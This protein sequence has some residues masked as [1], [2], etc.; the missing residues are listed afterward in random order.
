MDRNTRLTRLRQLP[1][2]F[3]HAAAPPPWAPQP[4]HLTD[5]NEPVLAG[6][7]E[8]IP[9]ARASNTLP[10]AALVLGAPGSGKTHL[11]GALHHRPASGPHS[12]T[13]VDVTPPIDP[14]RPL[15]HLAALMVAALA[16]R[17]G[18]EPP[19][20]ARMLA[21]AVASWLAD[22]EGKSA[23]RAVK[24]RELS[25]TR[26]WPEVAGQVSEWMQDRHPELWP[27]LL[28]VLIQYPVP[29]KQPRAVQWLRGDSLSDEEVAELGL[30]AEPGKTSA[31]LENA[32][33]W[34]IASLT[35]LL[36]LDRPL[37]LAFDALESEAWRE[38]RSVLNRMLELV[39]SSGHH[40]LVLACARTDGWT[41]VADGLEASLRDR[42]VRRFELGGCS[43]PQVDRLVAR[44]LAALPGT[45]DGADLFPLDDALSRHQLMDLAAAGRPLAREVLRKARQM[46][47][48]EVSGEGTAESPVEVI[49]VWLDER[50]GLI[51]RELD[52]YPPEDGVLLD[53]IGWALEHHGREEAVACEAL[54]K[55]TGRGQEG[56][57][58]ARLRTRA[59]TFRY[60]FVAG[61]R[62]EP[63]TLA[64]PVWQALRQVTQGELDIPVVV[65]DFRCPVPDFSRFPG[66]S[67]LEALLDAGGYL[68]ELDRRQMARCWAI[69]E[70]RVAVAAQELELLASD[71]E[72]QPVTRAHL[73]VFMQERPQWSPVLSAL[74][75]C[76]ARVRDRRA[77]Q[78]PG[79]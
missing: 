8:L 31:D 49:G 15:R 45:T 69:R 18:T 14:A 37:V 48:R 30:A 35:R 77:K 26:Q 2:P 52:R 4:G 76:A 72:L 50:M 47:M 51:E 42:F 71:G 61:T 27:P 41:R 40:L 9:A 20:L 25:L 65:R 64:D 6:L 34:R 53:G 74:A 22:D 58:T 70:L 12:C 21:R 63:V 5:L 78:N 43:R 32:A 55:P 57:M 73:D 54:V 59:G 17:V 23:R 44:R 62:R 68:L 11:L 66:R 28:E 39:L 7:D 3:R 60:R 79:A 38:R 19:A 75:A 24:R 13:V 16:Q 1:S 36:E 46:W 67:P 29:A 56:L 33:G 10:Q